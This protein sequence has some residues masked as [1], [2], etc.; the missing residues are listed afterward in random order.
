MPG[1]LESHESRWLSPVS[2]CSQLSVYIQKLLL[3]A[4]WLLWH[5]NRFHWFSHESTRPSH[6]PVVSHTCGRQSHT[7]YKDTALLTPDVT[8]SCGGTHCS[9]K[10]SKRAAIPATRNYTHPLSQL[11]MLSFTTQL[12]RAETCFFLL[13]SKSLELT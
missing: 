6:L 8:A 11:E 7:L 12:S 5:R 13:A 1:F 2:L 3:K 9:P 4:L 10:D